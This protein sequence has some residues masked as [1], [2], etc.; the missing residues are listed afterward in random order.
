MTH[1]ALHLAL[2]PAGPGR[3]RHRFDQMVRTQLKES[4]VDRLRFLVRRRP[5]RNLTPGFCDP[6]PLA[7]VYPHNRFELNMRVVIQTPSAEL[8]PCR[9]RACLYRLDQPGNPR[10][11]PAEEPALF[12]R[13]FVQVPN[14]C[15]ITVY[16]YSIP[17]ALTHRQVH[18]RDSVRHR[19]RAHFGSTHPAPRVPALRVCADDLRGGY[20][21]QQ[22]PSARVVVVSWGAPF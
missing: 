9:H 18:T 7:F 10:G 12:D 5:K 22:F 2:L 11:D 3:A 21:I 16:L 20:R 19:L 1:L 13:Q 4:S 17:K 14:G 8:E 6:I 15:Q